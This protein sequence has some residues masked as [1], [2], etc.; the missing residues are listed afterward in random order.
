MEAK[1]HSTYWS[2]GKWNNLIAFK[3]FCD[4]ISL[5]TLDWRRGWPQTLTPTINI[6]STLWNGS[7][8]IQ[9]LKYALIVQLASKGWC[10]RHATN[11]ARWLHLFWVTSEKQ[12]RQLSGGY[13]LFTTYVR[14]FN[15]SHWRLLRFQRGG[16]LRTMLQRLNGRCRR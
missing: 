11:P 6:A 12:V 7:N 15:I 14:L 13:T 5:A 10:R 16:N 4:L 2:Y 3:Y 1:L 9:S 8:I